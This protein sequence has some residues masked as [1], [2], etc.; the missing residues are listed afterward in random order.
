MTITYSGRVLW[1]N[2]APLRD[3]QVR[4]F[5]PKDG[6][7]LGAELTL[8]PALTAPDGSFTIQAQETPLIDNALLN[9]L[10]LLSSQFDEIDASQTGL[11]S[12]TRPILQF[13]Y[14]INGRT[15]RLLA[16]FR[17]LHRA[18]RL[19]HYPPVSFLPSRDGF[20]FANSFD[21]FLPT[22]SLPGWLGGKRV[23]QNYGLCGGMSSAAYDFCLVKAGDPLAPNIRQYTIVPK[24]GSLLQRYLLRRSLDTFGAAGSKVARVGDWTLLPDA[25]PA[26]T[27]KLT[28]DEFPAIRQSLEDGQCVVL[29]LI[30]ER[31]VDFLSMAKQIWLNHQVLAYGVAQTGS[32]A[33]E[34]SIYNSNYP[35]R[36][37][38]RLQIQCVQEGLIQG[39]PVFGMLTHETVPG[40]L[41]REVRG[42]F[43]MEYTQ[44][45]P[46][47]R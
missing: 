1:A 37:D 17:K 42:F 19:A 47:G 22:I 4:L 21:P 11:G 31:A 33:Y 9:Q 34:I 10:E 8:Q 13:S 3:V 15:A 6:G 40:E 41:P 43:P 20:A 23:P 32:D 2:G 7:T 27:Q 30:Y 39:N 38:I 29:T 44:A 46:P 28:L 25:G 14:S 18:Y 12:E 16:V 36:D 5:E 35:N 24:N 26:G 45:D